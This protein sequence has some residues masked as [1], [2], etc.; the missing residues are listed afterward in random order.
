MLQA[1]TPLQMVDL[2]DAG[3]E[4]DRLVRQSRGRKVRLLGLALS[5]VAAIL[6]VVVF[7]ARKPETASPSGPEYS[8]TL[9]LLRK[10]Q[11]ISDLDPAN[12]DGYE[13]K[14]VGDGFIMTAH[15]E[16]GRE[17]SYILTPMDEG[18]SFYLVSMNN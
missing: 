17:A 6:I 9:D 14:P 5:G 2:P 10:L 7:L 15:F 4:F 3:D 8:D 13:F 12:A 1:I 11:F 16:D 18:Q